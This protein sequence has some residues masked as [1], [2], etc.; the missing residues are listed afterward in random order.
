MR[1]IWVSLLFAAWVDMPPAP[2]AADDTTPIPPDCPR[3]FDPGHSR[4]LREETARLRA[5]GYAPSERVDPAL[6]WDGL[7]DAG[8]GVARGA[9]FV[10]VRYERSRFETAKKMIVL[11]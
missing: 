10:S 1:R 11:R 5:S 9:Y 3:Q 4:V 8:R 7:D 2:A 6:T